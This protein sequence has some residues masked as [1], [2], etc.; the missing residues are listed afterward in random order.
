MNYCKS[1]GDL[2][3]DIRK[4]IL[5]IYQSLCKSEMLE[6]CVHVNESF[7]RIIGNRVLK[8]TYDGLDV[9]S[10]GVYDI[11]AHFN[12]GEKSAL[13]AMELLKID[14]GYHMT[15]SCRFTNMRRKSSSIYSISK[16]QKKR[17]KL[18]HHSKK[19]NKANRLKLKEPHMKRGAFKI[20]YQLIGFIIFCFI[21]IVNG[22]LCWYF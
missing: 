6:K 8:A 3:I 4:A 16:P 19:S 10:V 21:C 11:T 9:S 2:T 1:K 22:V 15:K 5:P 12:N 20:Q 13:A 14:P 18:L 7:N 17:R